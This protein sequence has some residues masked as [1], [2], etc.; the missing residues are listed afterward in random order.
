M[1]PVVTSRWCS[2][3]VNKYHEDEKKKKTSFAI[4]WKSG[5]VVRHRVLA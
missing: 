4:S 3:G 1:E 5:I 2:S